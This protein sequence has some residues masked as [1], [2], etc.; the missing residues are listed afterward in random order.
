MPDSCLVNKAENS[1]GNGLV[2]ELSAKATVANNLIANSGL[3]GILISETGHVQ[4]WNNTLSGNHRSINIVEGDRIATNLSQPGHD[5]RQKLPDPTVTWT[6]EDITV[7]NNIL[8][9]GDGKCVLCVEDYSHK[10]SA[11]QMRVVS[12]GNVIHRISASAPKWA[13]V[14]SRGPG[15]PAVY[16]SLAEFAAATGQDRHSLA[17]DGNP[18]LSDLMTPTAVVTNAAQSVARPLPAGIAAL[19][20]GK[21][22]VRHLG[23]WK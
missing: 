23:A 14:W 4:V 13:V 3:D 22:G 20:G 12:E 7:S 21:A 19:A 15:N 16:N 1:T 8:A 17:M 5:K 18:V 2:L 11:A 6:T 9:S 10:R